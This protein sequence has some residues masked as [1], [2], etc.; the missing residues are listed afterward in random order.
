LGEGIELC[1]NEW[2][3]LLQGNMIAKEKKN[4]D[5]LKKILKNQWAN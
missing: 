2:E 5:N 4:F 3:A 1:S